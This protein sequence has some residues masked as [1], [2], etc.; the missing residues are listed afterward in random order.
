MRNLA[1]LTLLLFGSV[2]ALAQKDQPPL[3]AKVTTESSASWQFNSGNDLWTLCQKV[4]LHAGSGR[5]Y[6]GFCLGYIKGSGEVLEFQKQIHTP[7]GQTNGQLYDTVMDWLSSHPEQ[8]HLA[9]LDVVYLAL[10]QRFP[11]SAAAK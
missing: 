1:I 5:A 7:A 10:Q 6:R 2:P 4:D 3:P 9:A 11:P 8:R